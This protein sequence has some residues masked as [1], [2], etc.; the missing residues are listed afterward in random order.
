MDGLAKRIGGFEGFH[1]VL[2]GDMP[3]LTIVAYAPEFEEPV[4]IL[5]KILVKQAGLHEPLVNSSYHAA[6]L[7]IFKPFT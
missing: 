7:A 6:M 4:E 3:R 5:S 1:G 2:L